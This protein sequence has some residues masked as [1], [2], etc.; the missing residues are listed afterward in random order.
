MVRTNVD[1]VL[2]CGGWERRR[3]HYNLSTKAL[4]QIKICDKVEGPG[5]KDFN[6]MSYTHTSTTITHILNIY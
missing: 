4:V 2:I 5:S 6:L 1:W 3:Q